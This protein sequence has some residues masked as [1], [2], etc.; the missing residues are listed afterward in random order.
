MQNTRRKKDQRRDAIA[1]KKWCQFNAD[2][3]MCD[4]AGGC[5]DAAA[6]VSTA[7]YVQGGGS[8]ELQTMTKVEIHGCCRREGRRGGRVA[9]VWLTPLWGWGCVCVSDFWAFGRNITNEINIAASLLF[10]V[11]RTIKSCFSENLEVKS[12]ETFSCDQATS[13]QEESWWY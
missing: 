13:I 11:S 3:Y 6:S 5:G 10:S 1:I 7:G 8:R 12:Q 9:V 2:V 4:E